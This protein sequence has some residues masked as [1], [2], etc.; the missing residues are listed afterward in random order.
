MKTLQN[1]GELRKAAIEEMNQLMWSLEDRAETMKK[2]LT[3]MDACEE[4]S[5]EVYETALTVGDIEGE[6]DHE[7]LVYL[8]EITENWPDV[9]LE[10]GKGAYW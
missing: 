2:F 6:G 4:W 7:S 9:S 10:L 3:Y 5:P 1:Y 8:F